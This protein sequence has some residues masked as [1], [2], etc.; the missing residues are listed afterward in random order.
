MIKLYKKCSFLYLPTLYFD[1]TTSLADYKIRKLT[2]L[3]LGPQNVLFLFV[4]CFGAI[5][6]Y[7]L[8]RPPK[9]AMLTA[10]YNG[11]CI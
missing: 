5:V 11:L 10:G 8:S 3:N 9:I 2:P 7:S 1:L 6:S 4:C